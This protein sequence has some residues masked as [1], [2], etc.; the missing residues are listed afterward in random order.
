VKNSPHLIEVGLAVALLTIEATVTLAVAA[1]ALLLT[2]ARWRPAATAPAPVPSNCPAST[3]GPASAAA[4]APQEHRPAAADQVPL[5]PVPHP[6]AA[7]ATELQALSVATL[8]QMVGPG[9]RR[10]R[11]S[12]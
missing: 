11:G 10:L 12:T 2:L 8:R 6:L 1:L 5:A 4:V 9:G 3:A 7:V